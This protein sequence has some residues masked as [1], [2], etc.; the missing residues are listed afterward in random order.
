MTLFYV[1]L[2]SPVAFSVVLRIGNEENCRIKSRWIS[3]SG[4]LTPY[5]GLTGKQSLH[6][7]RKDATSAAWSTWAGLV[8]GFSE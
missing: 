1:R 8:Q 3:G 4:Q 6:V 5:H 7:N 2:Y